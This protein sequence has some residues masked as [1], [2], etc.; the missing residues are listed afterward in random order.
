MREIEFRGLLIDRKWVYGDLVVNKAT[1]TCRIFE[2]FANVKHGLYTE[3]GLHKCSGQLSIVDSSTIGQ[4]T[5]LKDKN[6]VK[7]FKHDYYQRYNYLYEVRFIEGSFVGVCVARL[8]D[9]TKEW[10]KVLESINVDGKQKTYVIESNCEPTT[11]IGNI[12]QDKHLIK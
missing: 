9:F 11:I 10:I 8:H 3:S 12:H 1:H 5:G 7:I 4:Y 6:G 2:N